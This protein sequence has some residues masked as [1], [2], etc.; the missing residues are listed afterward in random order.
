MLYFGCLAL[1]FVGVFIIAIN[2]ISG[3]LNVLGS[4]V[5]YLWDSF[6]NLFRSKEK[7]K[8]TRNPFASSSEAPASDDESEGTS[9]RPR[10]KIFDASEGEYIDF[11]EVQ[12]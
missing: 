9:A 8:A 12:K 1:L 4:V 11:E 5:V 3:V 6:C 2:L 10:G 7:R